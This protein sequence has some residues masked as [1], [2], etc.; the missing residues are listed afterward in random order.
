[1]KNIEKI[2]KMTIKDRK[3]QINKD[4]RLIPA[5]CLMCKDV[6]D[7]CYNRLTNWLK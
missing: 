2:Q 3:E 5:L 7:D 6:C 4:E 1:M